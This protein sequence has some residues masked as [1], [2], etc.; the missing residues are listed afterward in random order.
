VVKSPSAASGAAHT[1]IV[2]INAVTILRPIVQVHPV[3]KSGGWAFGWE[4]LAAIGTLILAGVTVRLAKS[5][6]RL[7]E[8]AQNEARAVKD[9]SGVVRE[10]VELQRQQI[11]AGQKPLVVPAPSAGWADGTETYDRRPWSMLLPVKNIGLGPALN[12][13]G[14]I[15]FGVTLSDEDGGAFGLESVALILHRASHSRNTLKRISD[16]RLKS[17]SLLC[18]A[19]SFGIARG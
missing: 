12:V 8:Q 14:K 3:L 11:E 15:D 17:A 7:A 6:S 5:T 2:V 10:Q 13:G 4:A 9:N 16:R 1:L 18:I 19:G